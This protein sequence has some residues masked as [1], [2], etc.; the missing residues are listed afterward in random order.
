MSSKKYVFIT[1]TSTS[2]ILILLA[3]FIV[4][5]DPYFHYHKPLS[6]IT[7]T[8]NNQRYQNDGIAKHFDYDAIITGTS[9]TENFKTSEADKLFNVK[10]VKLPFEG[11][12]FK[13]INNILN[14]ALTNNQNIKIII[15]C[16]DLYKFNIDKDKMQYDDDLYPTYLYDDNVFNDIKYILNKEIIIESFKSLIKTINNETSTSFDD[17]SI[18]YNIVTFSKETVD[19]QY[20]RS[21]SSD[22][23]NIKEEDY[24]RIHNNIKQ[25][26]IDLASKNPN[27][28]FYLFYPPYSIY[29]WDNLN[30]IGMLENQLQQIEY[31][32]SLLLEYPNIHLY[33]FLDDYETITNLDNYKDLEHYSEKINSKILISIKDNKHLITKD[34]YKEKIQEMKKYYIEFD[35][36]SLFK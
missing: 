6:N 29:Y 18:W 34:N 10:S 9:M 30:Q 1:L 4:I 20:N 28:T 22:K 25:N 2:I 19:S 7:Y 23:Q 35:Y 17:Y 13:E 24:E 36:N 26:V 31:V 33:S 21:V 14:K 32:T 16:L 12:T 5:I 3:I 15:R 11:A 27:V 8:L